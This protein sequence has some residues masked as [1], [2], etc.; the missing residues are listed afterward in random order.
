MCHENA[1]ISIPLLYHD[2]ERG[3]KVKYYPFDAINEKEFLGQFS[4]DWEWLSP[5]IKILPRKLQNL[6]KRIHIIYDIGEFIR[7][8]IFRD[9]LYEELENAN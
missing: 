4:K 2:M 5:D 1:F 6:C 9:R 3:F 8:V 7:Y